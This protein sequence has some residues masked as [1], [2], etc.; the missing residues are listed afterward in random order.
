MLSRVVR[1]QDPGDSSRWVRDD[2]WYADT[3]EAYFSLFQFLQENGLVN[4]RLV[5]A[6]ADVD[7]VVV[8]A[9]DLTDTGQLFVRSGVVDRWLKSLDRPSVRKNDFANTGTLERQLS[10]LQ[11][12][13]GDVLPGS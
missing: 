5:N 11:A 4:R 13:N 1:R 7:V 6:A 3:R 9:S 2:Q 10:K 12:G 8:L